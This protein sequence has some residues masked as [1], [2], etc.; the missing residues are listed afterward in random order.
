MFTHTIRRGSRASVAL[1]AALLTTLAIGATASSARAAFH[2]ERYTPDG[3]GFMCPEYTVV[4]G[5]FKYRW[6]PDG[7]F[8]KRLELTT[9]NTTGYNGYIF[10]ACRAYVYVDVLAGNGDIL[11]TL[12]YEPWA[13][14]LSTNV[15][16]HKNVEV[17]L[18]PDEIPLVRSIQIRHYPR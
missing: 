2:A 15:E 17:T 9:S 14:P 8:S 1:I 7:S 6:Y 18:E 10:A 11:G 5:G 3:N 13:G 4:D 12:E 16:H